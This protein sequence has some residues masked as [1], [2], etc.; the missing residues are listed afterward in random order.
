MKRTL[1]ILLWAAGIA[2]AVCILIMCTC[3]LVIVSNAKGKAFSEIES[4]QPAEYGLLLGTTP[5][6]RIG[7]KQNYFFTFRIDATERLYKAGKI[8]KILISGDEN[9]L[10]GVNEV[11]CMRDSLVGRGVSPSDII[12]DGKGY[13]TLDSVVRAAQV[14][15]IRS[16]IVISQQ[17]HNE[18]AIYLAEHLNLGTH[19]IA[20]FNAADV[21]FTIA[22][23]T[24]IRE[25]FARVKVFIDIFTH[26]EPLSY[27]RT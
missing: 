16:F 10:D 24:Y 11:V 21:R 5:Q 2:A 19:H 17:F 22:I 6:T 14:Y 1:Q 3:N 26:K 9:S 18:R 23:V 13:R 25:Y 7:R 15:G 20:A 27:T 4:I 8:R 12:L